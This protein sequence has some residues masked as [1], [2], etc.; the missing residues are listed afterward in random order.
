MKQ[1]DSI[2]LITGSATGIGFH[3]ARLL[4]EEGYHVAINGLNSRQVQEAVN[5]L[6]GPKERMLACPGDISDINQIDEIFC[7]IEDHWGPVNVLVNNA[8]IWE[9]RPTLKITPEI[10]QKMINVNL[11]G[12]FFC[13]RRALSEMVKIRRGVIINMTSIAAKTGG[14]NPV[15]HY[16]A[17]KAGVI[18][19]TKSWATEFAPFGIRVNGIAPGVIETPM[20]AS[21][22]KE[23]SPGIPLK[24]AGSP[25]DVAEAVLFLARQINGYITGEIIDVNGGLYMD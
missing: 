8:G 25:E 2:C 4:L 1:S 10:W 20:T 22:V 16:A 9:I 24:K 3:S 21:I 11:S 12:L 19:L 18:A 5:N 23:F 17:S 7:K 13:G 15:P 14:K 6:G